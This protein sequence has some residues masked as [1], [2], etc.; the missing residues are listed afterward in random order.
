MT[1][2][3]VLLDKDGTLI[4][5]VPM[6]VDPTRI[7]LSDG[8]ADALR[9]LAEAGC[10]IAVV[11]NQSGVAFGHFSEDAL[12]GVEQRLRELLAECGATLDGFFYCPHHPDGTVA[13]YRRACEC[14]K[15]RSALVERAMRTL[16]VTPADTWL[17]GD[18]LD[19]IEAAHRAGARAILF[20]SGG[21]TEWQLS[22]VRMPDYVVAW[23]DEIADI[24]LAD[25][26]VVV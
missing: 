12:H 25:A 2:R 3:A 5:N 6:N 20:D 23:L 18:I 8:A 7:R 17:V 24:I 15:P 21:E 9:R 19:D 4:E 1:T 11:S 10:R 16:G 14:R 26:G 22:P 13:E